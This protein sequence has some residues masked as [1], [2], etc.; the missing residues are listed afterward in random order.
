MTSQ[1]FEM[2]FFRHGLTYPKTHRETARIIVPIITHSFFVT[3]PMS[4]SF[5][6]ANAGASGVSFVSGGKIL[7][8]RYGVTSKDKIAGKLAALNHDT[9]G[10]VII[11]PSSSANFKHNKFCAAAV[12]NKALELPAA[13]EVTETS[14]HQA[15]HIAE[16]I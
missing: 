15:Y 4:F 12:R 6:A 10:F 3:G 13:C 14:T 11:T 7:Y 1:Y 9:H 16:S 5:S 2:I 8:S